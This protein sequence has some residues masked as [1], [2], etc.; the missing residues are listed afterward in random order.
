[1]TITLAGGSD[2]AFDNAGTAGD[3]AALMD[4]LSRA[5]GAQTI[6]LSSSFGAIFAEELYLYAWAPDDATALATVRVTGPFAG[7]P[8]DVGG[9]WTPVASGRWGTTY[10]WSR[11]S[12]CDAAWPG[13]LV[14]EIAPGPGSAFTSLNGLQLVSH[15]YCGD[16][17]CNGF[18]GALATC[19]CGNRGF[20][21]TG[22]D[23]AQST[24]GVRLRPLAQSTSPQ[25]RA[26]LQ[27]TAFPPAGH[28]GA[29]VLRA[30]LDPAGPSPF[31]DGVLCIGTPLVRLGATQASGGTSLHAFGHGTAPGHGVFFYQVWYR[32]QP[33]GFCEPA[34]AFNLSSATWLAW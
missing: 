26:T 6:T 15:G 1:V 34:A 29:V 20:P 28:P 23:P 14:I 24:G 31:G 17:L 25:N 13:D 32:N 10:A 19:P 12:K 2:L 5:A 3:D 16:T 30:G 7:A 18:D 8:E 33:T 22:C 11:V 9:A 4:D 21:T 27:G